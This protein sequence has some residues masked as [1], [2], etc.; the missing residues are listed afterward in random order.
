MA[1]R[2]IKRAQSLYYSAEMTINSK[3]SF[4]NQQ[5][6]QSQS[7]AASDLRMWDKGFPTRCP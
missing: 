5:I 7:A 1:N 3:T 4:H 2:Y 6:D